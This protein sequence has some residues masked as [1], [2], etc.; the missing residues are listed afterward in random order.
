MNPSRRKF[1]HTSAAMS[2][3]A[4]TA[5][6]TVP[7]IGRAA[8]AATVQYGGSAWLGHYPAYLAMKS[9][10]FAAAGI[11]QQWQSF[12]T[13]SARMSA[14]LSGGIDIACT[15][16]V[17]ALALM[18]RGSKHFS[19]VAVPESF[20]RV[21]GLFVR[22][23]VNSLQDLKGKKLGVTFASSAHLL[24]LDLLGSAGLSNDVTVLNV[25]APEIP[26][27]IQSGQIDA[28]AAWTPQFNRIRAMSGMKLL[29]D[30][31][32]FSLY[33]RYN[34]T[35]GPDVLIVRNAW[36]EKN[37]DVVRKYLKVYFDA[38]QTLRDKPDEAA[39]SLIG[40]TGMSA[41]DQIETIKGAEWYSLAQQTQLLK[42]PGSYVDGLQRLAE[43]LVTYKQI[44]KAPA[45][46]QWINTSYL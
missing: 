8:D 42:S 43:M 14:V 23:G 2:A 24:V 39:R 30:D 12:G 16:I 17:S 10:A 6:L 35:P 29:A 34:V 36:A 44:D 11:D 38:C 37:G 4:A 7:G 9:G 33:K 20:G 18:A 26:G 45:V 13:S 21:E 31:T 27:A 28:A 32:Q 46:R 3:V 15:G 19:I 1:L 5:G 22:E 41:L 25:P 40:L